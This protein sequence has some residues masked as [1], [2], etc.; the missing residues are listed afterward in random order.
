[1]AG[2][3]AGFAVAT[4]QEPP[5]QSAQIALT[6]F[7]KQGALLGSTPASST[8]VV[9]A[10]E[11][12]TLDAHPVVAALADGTYVVAW[13]GFG[14]DGDA[15]GVGLSSVDPQTGVVSTTPGNLTQDFS[16]YDPDLLAVGS[17][18]VVAWA[19]D[20]DALGAPDVYFREVGLDAQSTGTEQALA[21]TSAP[22][23]HVALARLGASWGAAWRAAAAG[24]K[25]T[26]E[27][28][29]RAAGVRWTVGPHLPGPDTDRPALVQLDA[30][31]R[32]LV[33]SEGLD[34]DGDGLAL[35]GGLRLALLS[36]AAPGAT[37]SQPLEFGAAYAAAHVGLSLS[38]PALVRV[39]DHL[40]L[41]W[42]T[43]AASGDVAGEELWRLQLDAAPDATGV[44]LT[45]GEE[46][47][48]PR[49]PLET[50]GD[51][52]H[53][54]LAPVEYAGG[55]GAAVIAWED[56]GRT[57]SDH[58][59]GPDVI[60]QL[61]PLPVVLGPEWSQSCSEATPC[62]A[63][64]YPCAA[65]VD[66]AAGL[67][68]LSNV[69][70]QWGA[71]PGVGVCV[72]VGCANGV[73]DGDET[74]VDCGGSC[75]ACRCGDGA[76][77][78]DLG[79]QCDDGNRV[80]T[81]ACRNDCT[82][83]TC[84]DH[85]IWAGCEQC[86]EG[87]TQTA[88]CDGDCT[89]AVCGDGVTNTLAGETC[90]DGPSGSA[91]CDSDCTLPV[92]GDGVTNTLAGEQCDAG[93]GGSASCDSDCTL[94]L[95]GDGVT[96][97]LAGEQCDDAN[98]N[99]HDGC[100]NNCRLNVCG[101]GILNIPVEACDTMVMSHWCN[102]PGV[103]AA[104]CQPPV[105]GDGVVNPVAGEL[106]EPS[107]DVA[108]STDC[109]QRRGCVDSSLCLY[110]ALQSGTQSA[111]NSLTPWLQVVNAGPSA[112]DLSQ[113]TVKYWFTEE[114]TEPMELH[115]DWANPSCSNFS[116]VISAWPTTAQADHVLTLSY[117]G[118][119]SLPA[120][121]TLGPIQLRLNKTNWSNF[122]ETNDHSWLGSSSYQ[123]ATK[124]A[125][126]L[127]GRLVWG[128]EPRSPYV[129]GNGVVEPG[130][131][132][133]SAGETA[134]C[135]G[136]CTQATCGDGVTNTAAG[137]A[138]DPGA[139]DNASCNGPGYGSVSCQPSRCGDFHWNPAAEACDPTVHPNCATDC[140]HWVGSPPSC[141]DGAHC[142][143]VFYRQRGSYSD[144]QLQPDLKLTNNSPEPI[145][146]GR[147][148]LRYWFSAE[149][150]AS[151]VFASWCDWLSLHEGGSTNYCNQTAITLHA[152]AVPKA[153]ASH[154]FELAFATDEV[155]QPGASTAEL[156]VRIAKSDW[157]DFN[158]VDDYSNPL[159]Y[160]YAATDHIALY[161]DE[162]LL[163]GQEP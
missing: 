13:T 62:A 60:V 156:Q 52:R 37:A 98:D 139:F 43:S 135:D 36:T 42:S 100:L 148:K 38:Q 150:D 19:D 140:S 32:L 128:I 30:T 96:N 31:R 160:L 85:I 159:S 9:V 63:G 10:S 127:G 143:E 89:L 130:E 68:C 161:Y 41:S 76:R 141:N 29:D 115:C 51:Q 102:G 111:D 153:G 122:D 163:W 146:F 117:V 56:Y 73:L 39:G 33:Y 50:T 72:P 99:M 107:L 46:Q 23:G 55:D 134:S 8:Q 103:G 48:L 66:C 2:G 27:V 118:A 45:L 94:A 69:S 59:G 18:Y 120:G 91:A 142:L 75:G 144:N 124:V 82:L 67:Q 106:C 136:D 40:L 84:G 25:E 152:M 105:C 77:Q 6:L 121:A 109:Q 65:D 129:C 49:W 53:P 155:L 116:G 11:L 108:C 5:G 4:V 154:Y 28:F 149:G 16:Q 138:C 157:S 137:E 57:L 88:T 95:C 61:L 71:G 22:E 113:L 12:A 20:R 147:L 101:D 86:D 70:A 162:Q 93:P 17:G 110:A 119:G 80:D 74:G 15:L 90:D 133:D 26:I 34:P 47:P 7:G 114:G 97:A 104:S 92:C 44:T 78:S 158:E 123:P 125:L 112:V 3:P 64:G 24:G 87:G 35:T 14:V 126:Y 54:A 1:V 79:E 131:Q 151:T 58:Q 145:A 21:V 132:C 81:D 83:P